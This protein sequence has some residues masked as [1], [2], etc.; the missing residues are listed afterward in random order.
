MK[1][2]DVCLAHF[3]FTD[4]TSSKLRTILI[5]SRDDHNRGEDVVVLPISSRPD[6][7]DPHSLFL[8]SS[9]HHN[10][11]LKVPSSIKWYKPVTI[12]KIVIKRRLGSLSS[13]ILGDVISRLVSVFQS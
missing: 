6:P 12:S 5:V 8:D 10:A 11:G 4:G 13:E 3:P 1:C 2:G 7:G 9:Q